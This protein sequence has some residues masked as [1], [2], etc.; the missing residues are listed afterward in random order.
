[1]K[2][3]SDQAVAAPPG[4]NLAKW[5]AGFDELF[6]RLAWHPVGGRSSKGAP[7]AVDNFPGHACGMVTMAATT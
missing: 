4:L 1:M 3:L 2:E 7:A 5:R 6:A